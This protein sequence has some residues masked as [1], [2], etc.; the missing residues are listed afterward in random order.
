MSWFSIELTWIEQDAQ[1]S[2]KEVGGRYAG[3][4]ASAPW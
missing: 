4:G 3:Q 1:P 2:E